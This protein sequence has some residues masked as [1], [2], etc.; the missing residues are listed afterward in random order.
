M[1]VITKEL[2]TAILPELLPLFEMHY[3]ETGLYRQLGNRLAPVPDVA[4]YA[5]AERHGVLLVLTA[6]DNGKLIGY[7][8][9]AIHPAPHYADTLSGF[10]DLPYVRPEYRHRGIGIR[11]FIEAEKEMRRRG[12]KLWQASAKNDSG[13]FRSMD[14]ALRHIGFSPTDT[15]YYKWLG[16]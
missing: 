5:M 16:G 11:L 6:R 2:F 9:G 4:R 10:T 13:T 1:T 7:Y 15:I 14:R 12:V 3:H 8:I